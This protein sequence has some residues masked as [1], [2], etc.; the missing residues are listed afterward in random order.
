MKPKTH[1]EVAEITAEIAQQ[2][3]DS[4]DEETTASEKAHGLSISSDDNED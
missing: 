3:E 1:A 4:S 2:E